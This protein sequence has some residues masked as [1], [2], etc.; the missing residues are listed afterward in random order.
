MVEGYCTVE[1]VMLIQTTLQRLLVPFI[2]DMDTNTNRSIC[3]KGSANAHINHT[4]CTKKTVS[5]RVSA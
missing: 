2:L 4:T 1:A 5:T 3:T